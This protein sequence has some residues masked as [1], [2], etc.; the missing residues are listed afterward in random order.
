MTDLEVK[1][2]Q[3]QTELDNATPS[4]LVARKTH[5]RT[6]WLLEDCSI[7]TWGYDLA[8][9]ERTLNSHA[10]LD[11]DLSGARGIA[12]LAN[13]RSNL[14]IKLSDP[15]EEYENIRTLPGHNQSVIS[16]REALRFWEIYRPAETR[17]F[18]N[19]HNPRKLPGRST[20]APRHRD[21]VWSYRLDERGLLST[22]LD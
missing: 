5:N 18:E 20:R 10:K 14:A 15:A 2:S 12:L 6:T 8:E 21:W 3:L 19:E 17:Q 9:I 22:S 7:N 1:A 13:C 11:V 16:A 4:S